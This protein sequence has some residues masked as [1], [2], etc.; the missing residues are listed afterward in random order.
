MPFIIRVD[1]PNDTNDTCAYQGTGTSV[2]ADVQLCP[3]VVVHCKNLI[4]SIYWLFLS[5][6][7]VWNLG[8]KLNLVI[9]VL[10][11]SCVLVHN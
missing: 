1:V 10:K 9:S 4:S 5:I 11:Y 7:F 6:L 3:E 8:L 2:I